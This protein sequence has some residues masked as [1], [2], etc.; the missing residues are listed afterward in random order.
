MPQRKSRQ[1]S[2]RGPGGATDVSHLYKVLPQAWSSSPLHPH[3]WVACFSPPGLQTSIP[4]E[5]CYLLNMHPGKA[6]LRCEDHS[7]RGLDGVGVGGVGTCFLI[8]QHV[9][10]SSVSC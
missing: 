9:L 1:S 4:R 8:T 6:A 3:L 7:L 5:R 2:E 10:S